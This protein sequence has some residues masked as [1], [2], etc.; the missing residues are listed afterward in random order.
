MIFIQ[1]FSIILG[2][3]FIGELLNFLLPLPIPAS[4][5]GLLIMLIL[6]ST[7]TLALDKVKGAGDFLLDIMPLMFIPAAVGILTTW[8]ILKPILVPFVIITIL[9]TIF[10]MAVTGKMTQYVLKKPFYKKRK[11]T[12]YDKDSL[13]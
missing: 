4:I 13:L 11:E 5:Y 12:Q 10:V 8:S 6:L 1:Q 7:K 9:T 3:T 2:I